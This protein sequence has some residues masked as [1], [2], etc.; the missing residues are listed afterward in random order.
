MYALRVNSSLP[1]GT[2]GP[3]TVHGQFDRLPFVRT[4]AVIPA[5]GAAP[6][7][8]V[9][10]ICT[11]ATHAVTYVARRRADDVAGNRPKTKD[12]ATRGRRRPR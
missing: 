3:E 5:G 12:V 11:D 7:T 2:A 4:D 6:L 9:K 10:T 1:G 8:S